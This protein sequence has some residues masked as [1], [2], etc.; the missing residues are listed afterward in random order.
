MNGNLF[1]VDSFDD[2]FKLNLYTNN[3]NNDI[4]IKNDAKSSSSLNIKKQNEDVDGRCLIKRGNNYFYENCNKNLQFICEFNIT[5]NE[6][7]KKIKVS[8][9]QSRRGVV[10]TTTVTS[11][12]IVIIENEVLELEKQQQTLKVEKTIKKIDNQS[13]EN[14]KNSDFGK[15]IFNLFYYSLLYLSFLN[16]LLL[17]FSFNYWCSERYINCNHYSKC[18]FNLELL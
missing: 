17:F 11:K 6:M 5:T 12:T 16:F 2:I 8:C 4:W 3:K 1:E 9:G 10:S 18:I 15:T 14:F 13:N 7:N